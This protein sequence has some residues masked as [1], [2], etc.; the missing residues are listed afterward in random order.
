MLHTTGISFKMLPAVKSS[1]REHIAHRQHFDMT[2]TRRTRCSRSLNSNPFANQASI[3][4]KSYSSTRI[5]S[6]YSDFPVADAPADHQK[7]HD[8]MTTSTYHR[9]NSPSSATSILGK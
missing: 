3:H 4:S 6:N 5:L 9:E 1:W 2:L 8:Q 7:K